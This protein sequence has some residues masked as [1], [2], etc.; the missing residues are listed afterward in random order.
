MCLWGCTERNFKKFIF[1]YL[2]FLQERPIACIIN[3]TETINQVYTILTTQ[4]SK[5]S[6]DLFKVLALYE[7]IR[8]FKEDSG[9]LANQSSVKAIKIF[10]IRFTYLANTNSK[11]LKLHITIKFGALL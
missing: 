11:N 6:R 10:L 9:S 3:W 4:V 2:K 5:W 1:N 8:E 7:S